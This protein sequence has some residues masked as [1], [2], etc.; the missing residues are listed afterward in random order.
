MNTG[1][2]A[3]S[4]VVGLYTD[5]S[6]HPGVLL[7][8]ATIK[9]PKAGRWDSA[10]VPPANVSG[11]ARYWLAAL[12]PSGTLAVRDMASSGG[13]ANSSASSSLTQLPAAWSSGATWASSP[14]SFYAVGKAS[15]KPEA[16]PLNVSAPSVSGVRGSRR[17]AHRRHGLLGG[18]PD[19]LRIPVAGVQRP[20]RRLPRHRRGAS[21]HLHP[22]RRRAGRDRAGRGGRRQR[23]GLDGGL[24]TG[25]GRGQ[26]HPRPH[27][28]SPRRRSAALPSSAKRSARAAGAGRA[29]PPRT[30]TSGNGVSPPARRSPARAPRPGR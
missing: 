10:R 11:G 27:P 18:K 19:L 24:L 7:A 6:G 15:K 8:G 13:P 30:P 22:R 26:R 16:V 17:D 1:S 12:A 3:S 2:S 21:R 14:A 4:I 25:D 23:R 29:I 20:R 9:R 5:S 28:T